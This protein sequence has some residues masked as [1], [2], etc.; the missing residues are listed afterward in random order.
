MR[1]KQEQS[2]ATLHR[3]LEAVRNYNLEESSSNDFEGRSKF[4]MI[5]PAFPVEVHTI[6]SGPTENTTPREEHLDEGP[7]Q[8]H[9]LERAGSFKADP[10]EVE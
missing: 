4:K 1:E 10:D 2:K 5:E 6:G 9:V 7:P 3:I 8:T